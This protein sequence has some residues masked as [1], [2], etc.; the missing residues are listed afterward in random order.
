LII[1]AP[2]GLPAI[3]TGCPLPDTTEGLLTSTV[4]TAKQGVPPYRWAA[5]GQ[6]GGFTMS[7]AGLFSGTG[8]PGLITFSVQATDQ[9]LQIATLRCSLTINPKPVITTT[10]LADGTTGVDYLQPVAAT[11]GTGALSWSASGLP[12]GLTIGPAGGGI[13]GTPLSGGTASVNLRVSDKLGVSAAKSFSL[14]IAVNPNSPTPAL[15]NTCPLTSAAAGVAYT[16]NLQAAGGTPPYR[17]FVSNLPAGITFDPATGILSGTAVSGSSGG[18]L[19]QVID[20]Q[21]H[22]GVATCGLAVTPAAPLHDLAAITPAA[23]V[24]GAYTG[25][26]TVAGGVPP[27]RWSLQNG[28]LPPGIILDPSGTLRGLPT[29]AGHFVFTVLVTDAAGTS[30]TSSVTIDVAPSLTIATPPALPDGI[31]GTAY[32]QAL[33]ANGASGNVTW[34][35]RGGALPSGLTLDPATGVISGTPLAAGAFS[36]TVRAVDALQQQVETLLLITIRLAPLPPV[37]ITGP[38]ATLNPAQQVSVGMT[39]AAGYPL[40]I[41]GTLTLSIVPE[42]SVGI[43]DAQAVF[44]GGGK[45]LG[46]RI[47][48]NATQAVFDDVPAFQSGTLAA[49]IRLDAALQSGGISVSPPSPATVSVQVPRLAPVIVGT[50]TVI[51]TPTGIQISLIAF[52]TTR[53][54]SAAVFHFSGAPGTNL[55]GTDITVPLLDL[56]AA[57]YANPQSLLVGSQ[58]GLVQSFNVQGNAAQITTVTITLSNTVGNSQTVSVTF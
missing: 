21:S 17:W 57:W 22:V 27:Y 15:A 5:T 32:T 30:A 47:P 11:G 10:A 55:Q 52:S 42:A 19:I 7:A 2:G 29:S 20:S 45:T 14:A 12:A 56:V 13:N 28:A 43:A 23:K 53:Q 41:R 8:A 39:L 3:T 50:P 44:A 34:S 40:E 36:F 31:G 6:P 48:P 58:F 49:T 24:G 46:F 33:L 38:G 1:L 54:V 18:I 4:F 26:L 37:T 35:I 16:Q 25:S 51:R 9:Q